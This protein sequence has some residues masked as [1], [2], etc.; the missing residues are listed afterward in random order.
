MGVKVQ[1]KNLLKLSKK[2]QKVIVG[3]TS[4]GQQQRKKEI[5][6]GKQDIMYTIQS[7]LRATIYEFIQLMCV[8][9]YQI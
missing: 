3:V 1:I 2:F 7:K 9:L 4:L 8:F 6:Y 5:K